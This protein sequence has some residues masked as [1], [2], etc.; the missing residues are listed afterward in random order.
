MQYALEER[1]RTLP[2]R[3]S[4]RVA[5]V[6]SGYVAGQ[7]SAV[8]NVLGGGPPQPTVTPVFERG[9]NGRP[10]LVDNVETLAHIALI[11]RFGAEWFRALGTDALPGSSLVTVGG[12]VAYGGVYEIEP[13]VTM[14]ALVEAAGGVR[15]PVRALLVGGYAG[16]WLPGAGSRDVRVCPEGLADVQATLGAGLVYALGAD[17]CPVSELASVARWM[18]AESAQQ[19]GPCIHGLAAIATALED[20]ARGAADQHAAERVDRWCTM[21]MR[22]G[23]CGHPD[24]VARFVSSGLRTFRREFAEH[25]RGGPCE[26]CAEPRVLPVPDP[27]DAAVAA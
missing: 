14:G 13:G 10:T 15:Q 27:V 17:A 1:A 5:T 20:I 23:A 4:V 18:S 8:V 2:R 16:T 11:A 19:C 6:P 26:R 3:L 25:L 12:A 7:E 21:V 22:R 24:G 9:V